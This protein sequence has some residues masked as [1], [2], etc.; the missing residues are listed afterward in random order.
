MKYRLGKR[1]ENSPKSQAQRVVISSKKPS[2]S[3][4][5]SG[6]PHGPILMTIL[7]NIFINKLD[8]EAEYS[9][10]IIQNLEVGLIDQMFVPAFKGASTG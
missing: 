7:F 5:T 2:Q 1:I 3:P 6:V 8:N 9:L 4:D 10:Q